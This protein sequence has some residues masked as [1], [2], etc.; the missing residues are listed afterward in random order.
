[1][2]ECERIDRPLTMGEASLCSC[3]K[4]TVPIGLRPRLKA[5]ERNSHGSGASEMA[6][7]KLVETGQ[8]GLECAIVPTC[9]HTYRPFTTAGHSWPQR[10]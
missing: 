6:S 1:M 2:G 9:S 7:S 5:L 4:G 3:E 10:T 8:Y